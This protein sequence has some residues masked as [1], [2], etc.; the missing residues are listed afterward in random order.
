[1]AIR[2]L[3]RRSRCVAISVLATCTL[4]PA[5]SLAQGFEVL[6]NGVEISG[7]TYR[8]RRTAE[9]GTV[10][11]ASSAARSYRFRSIGNFIVGSWLDGGKEPTC[12]INGVPTPRATVYSKRGAHSAQYT[13][14][15]VREGTPSKY[16]E[17]QWTYGFQ[18]KAG[19]GGYMVVLSASHVTRRTIASTGG[20]FSARSTHATK[21]NTLFRLRIRDGACQVLERTEVFETRAVVVNTSGNEERMRLDFAYVNDPPAT[22]R[23]I[24]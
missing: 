21:G 16:T 10:E 18:S 14:D 6:G 22:C 17:E 7:G 1:M 8:L 11:H 13:C 19:A 9:D 15:P 12:P 2:A 5:P 4:P 24:D 3:A 23:L 20:G